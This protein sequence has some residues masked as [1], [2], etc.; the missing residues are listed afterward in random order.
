[1]AQVNVAAGRLRTL[2]ADMFDRAATESI[3]PFIDERVVMDARHD[4][5]FADIWVDQ[6]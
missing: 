3:D 4:H 2:S 5:P 6:R 1:M